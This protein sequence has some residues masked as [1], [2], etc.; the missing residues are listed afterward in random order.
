MRTSATSPGCTARRWRP[1]SGLRRARWERS[2][3]SCR[4]CSASRPRPRR[5]H[6]RPP[7]GQPSPRARGGHV[8]VSVLRL[9][10]RSRSR[11]TGRRKVTSTLRAQSDKH[12]HDPRRGRVRNPR[13]RVARPATPVAMRDDPWVMLL[14]VKLLLAPAFVVGASLV[15]RRFGPKVGGLV[16]GA[17]GGRGSDPA[18]VHA[19][20]RARVR[21]GRRRGHAAGAGV[22]DRVRGRLQPARGPPAVGGEHARRLA[23][24]RGGHGRAQRALAPARRRARPGRDGAGDR[25]GLAAAPAA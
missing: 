22:A 21:R 4:R 2:G 1:R 12:A 11:P 13:Y 23:G 18:R 9:C 3:R 5:T 8:G 14:A 16:G 6:P 19:R 24:V 17:A 20:A 7:S 10:A 15:T 25:P